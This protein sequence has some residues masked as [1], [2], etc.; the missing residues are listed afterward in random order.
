[1][2]EQKITVEKKLPVELPTL[3]DL[4]RVRLVLQNLIENAA[5][6]TDAGGRVKRCAFQ[7]SDQ[8]VVKIR[9]SGG[10]IPAEVQER[11]LNVSER[12]TAVNENV[13]GHGLSSNIARKIVDGHDGDLKLSAADGGWN[14]FEFRLAAVPFVPSIWIVRAMFC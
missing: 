10:T 8:A 11:V 3:G 5:K 14:E 7:E 12:G 6:P 13:R 4:S 9:N 2:L 1:M